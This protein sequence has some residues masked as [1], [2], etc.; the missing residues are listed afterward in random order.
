MR[1]QARGREWPGN[2]AASE[3]V[4]TARNEAASEGVETAWE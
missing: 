4:G 3:G 2:E 1:L